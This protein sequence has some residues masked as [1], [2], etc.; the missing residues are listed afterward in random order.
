MYYI[1]T[2][3]QVQYYINKVNEGERYNGVTNTWAT[4]L[5]SFKDAQKY[6]VIKHD[7]YEHIDMKLTESLPSEFVSIEL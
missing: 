5:Q 2:K 4:P 7:S 3:S 6:A 1:G